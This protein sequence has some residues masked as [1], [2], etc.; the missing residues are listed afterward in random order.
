MGEE[1]KKGTTNW[2]DNSGYSHVELY[3]DGSYKSFVPEID[4]EWMVGDHPVKL[5][6]GCAV[7]FFPD[8]S[9]RT[10]VLGSGAT[11]TVTGVAAYVS[12][13]RPLDLHENGSVRRMTLAAKPSWNPW[14]TK[15]WKYQGVVYEPR[16]TLEFSERGE[17][18]LLHKPN[19]AG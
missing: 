18:V 1:E 3:P 15:G 14:A 7:K 13:D 11:V 2:V 16:T 5:K 19:E 9:L 4:T 12:A 8:G 10:C 17:V 6:G